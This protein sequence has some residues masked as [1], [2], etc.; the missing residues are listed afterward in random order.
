MK[1]S[2]FL[3]LTVLLTAAAGPAMAAISLS[4]YT[5]AGQY[6]LPTPEAAETSGIA[7]D[8]STNSLYVMGDTA[9]YI[10][11]VSLTGQ[12][13]GSMALSGFADTEALAYYSPGKFLIAEERIQTVDRVTYQDGA[14]AFQSASSPLALGPF[15]NNDGI[16]GLTLDPLTGDL[17]AV[18]EKNSQAIYQVVN[19]AGGGTS[20]ITNP[21]S[22][23]GL[24][25]GDLSD[26]YALSNSHAFDT[27]PEGQN[28]LIISQQSNKL[29]EVNRSGQVL[30]TLDLSFLGKN[31]L[32]GVTMDDAGN[33]YITSESPTLYVFKPV[34]E[35]STALLGLACAPLLWRRRRN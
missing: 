16:E 32:E 15:A 34:P 23:A 35:A 25:L 26:I 2:R 7:Y 10:V 17:W 19:Y 3:P 4:T 31:N 13:R 14:V 27:K 6:A 30:G 29:V 33:L 22:P 12:Y 9:N 11:E 20:V 28:F 8:R 24:G 5:L 21:F 1:T 18:K